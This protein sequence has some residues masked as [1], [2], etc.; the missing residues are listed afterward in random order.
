MDWERLLSTS[1][2]PNAHAVGAAI[3][4]ALTEDEQIRF[5]KNIRPLVNAG[6]G[7]KREAF[8]YLLAVKT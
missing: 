1:P 4:D 5:E 7:T 3:R 6:K 8:A 2:N